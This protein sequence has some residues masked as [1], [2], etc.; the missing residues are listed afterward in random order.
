MPGI[1]SPDINRVALSIQQPWAELI[2][3]GI[4]TIEIRKAPTRIRGTVYLYAAK[5]FST[6]QCAQVALDAYNLERETLSRGCIVGQVD[7]LDCRVSQPDDA[8]LACVPEMMVQDTCSWIL[9]G[10]VRCPQLWP[11][12]HLPFGPWFYPFQRRGSSPGHRRMYGGS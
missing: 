4:K 5:Q 7:L 12:R 6:L 9:G 8:A 10:A 2:L 3:R 1:E 11:A